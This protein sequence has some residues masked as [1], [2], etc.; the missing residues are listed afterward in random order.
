MNDPHTD[1]GD[2]DPARIAALLDVTDDRTDE[3][4]E[5]ARKRRAILG[6]LDETHALN[7]DERGASEWL[8]AFLAATLIGLGA[9]TLA[10][11]ELALWLLTG[12][13]AYLVVAVA[14][15]CLLGRMS[16]TGGGR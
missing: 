6:S 14:L 13:L 10:Y 15:G 9:L 1:W 3:Q 5:I 4:R 12:S 8:H 16:R 11:P 2:V 7:R